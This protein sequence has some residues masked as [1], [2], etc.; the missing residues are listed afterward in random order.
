MSPARRTPPAPTC[1]PGEAPDRVVSNR[2]PSATQSPRH[3][4][5]PCG[6]SGASG[7]A[8][9]AS[10]SSGTGPPRQ[11][12]AAN[13]LIGPSQTAPTRGTG[14]SARRQPQARHHFPTTRVRLSSTHWARATRQR[15]WSCAPVGH[16]PAGALR[17][18]PT[19]RGNCFPAA[20]VPPGGRRGARTAGRSVAVRVQCHQAIGGAAR[21]IRDE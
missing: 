4:P 2:C 5:P 20:F 10:S 12:I 14:R 15:Q 8:M 1:G 16:R 11:M 18:P 19:G 17:R 6:P 9:R 13:A 3:V 7:A 21:L